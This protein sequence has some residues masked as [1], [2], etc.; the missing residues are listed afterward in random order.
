MKEYN[1][2]GTIEVV[3][4]PMFAGKTEELIRRIKRLEYAK[5]PYLVFTNKVDNRYSDTKIVSH[6]NLSKDAIFIDKSNEIYNYLKENTKVV[7]VD[8]AQFFDMELSSVVNDL[9][10]KG[11]RVIVGGLD[12]NFRG[13]PFG[14]MGDI[15]ALSDDILKLTAICPV[16]GKPATKTQRLV[17]GKPAKLSDPL[18]VIGEKESYEPRCRKCYKIGK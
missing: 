5:T 2:I 15:L 13:E 11:Y 17:N 9:A 14:P 16:C 7:V 8:E 1:I 6:S 3:C 12:Q 4:G 18:V 10:N